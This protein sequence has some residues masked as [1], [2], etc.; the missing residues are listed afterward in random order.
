[1]MLVVD[2]SGSMLDPIETGSSTSRLDEMKSAM[3]GFLTNNGEIARMGLAVFPDATDSASQCK[4][5]R[6]VQGITTSDDVTS[7]LQSAA[8]QINGTIQQIGQTGGMPARGGTPTAAT[9]R[10]IAEDP[11]LQADDSRQDIVLLLTDGLPNCNSA[12]DPQTCTC[13]TGSSCSASSCLD[14]V[15]SVNA[16]NDLRSKGI[17]TMVIGFGADTG[18][19]LAVD[20]LNAMAMA[21]GMARSCSRGCSTGESCDTTTNTCATK[22]YQAANAAALTAVLQEFSSILG[23][24][25]PCKYTFAD[26]KPE[27]PSFVVVYVDDQ[28]VSPSADTWNYAE[29]DGIP[30]VTFTG[31]ICTRLENAT[32]AQPVTVEIRLLD[33]L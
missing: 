3:G 2:K 18:G 13:T 27:D 17:Q 12:L 33:A 5:G 10:A 20:T 21:G 14:D 28:K 16:V 31:D 1:V 29:I 32:E 30:T 19:G 23:T 11:L 8:S 22:F 24:P 15:A 26:S 25:E 9:L 6:T 4:A 7:E